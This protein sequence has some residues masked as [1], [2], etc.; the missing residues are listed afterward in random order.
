VYWYSGAAG[1]VVDGQV[2]HRLHEELNAGNTAEISI[3]TPDDLACGKGRARR[4]L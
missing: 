2:L 3:K 1:A 4:D